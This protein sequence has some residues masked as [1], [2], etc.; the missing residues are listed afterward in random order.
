MKY[1]ELAAK[2]YVTDA[3]GDPVRDWFKALNRADKKAMGK[4]VQRVQI[5]WPVGR[6]LCAPLGRG[7]YEVR[8]DLSDNR[9]GRVLFCFAGEGT[10]VL[11][12]AFIKKAQRIP[13]PD[14][15]LARKRMTGG[16]P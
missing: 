12:H 7:L 16:R 5:G 1:M 10:I 13:Q 15:D 4:A 14:I 6:P 9:T 2:F 8:Q 11:L 3:G